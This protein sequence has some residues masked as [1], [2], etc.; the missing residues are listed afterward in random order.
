MRTRLAGVILSILVVGALVIGGL[1]AP[2][3]IQALAPMI[4]KKR[5]R[6]NQRALERAIKRLRD[7]RQIE[8]TTR[9]GKTVL[10]ITERGKRRWK[11]FEL[12]TLKLTVPRKSGQWTVILYDIPE[13]KKAARNALHQRLKALGCFQYHRS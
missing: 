10:Q 11:D 1:M 8:F 4:R 7:R 5:G 9:K 13:S 2:N 3:A 6:F 12:E